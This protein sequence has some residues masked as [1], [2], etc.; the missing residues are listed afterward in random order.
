MLRWE[1]A[2]ENNT[3]NMIEWTDSETKREERLF[4]N[5]ERNLKV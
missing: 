3:E 4:K 2:C 1:S 5:C